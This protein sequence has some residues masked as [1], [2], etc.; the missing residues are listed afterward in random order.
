MNVTEASA[1]LVSELLQQHEL[2]Q[3]S[4]RYFKAVAEAEAMKTRIAQRKLQEL[5]G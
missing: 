4:V 2:D 3:V 5:Q 1:Q